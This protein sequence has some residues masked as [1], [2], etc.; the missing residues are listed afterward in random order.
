MDVQS[1]GT[2]LH[3]DESRSVGTPF[4]RRAGQN[5]LPDTDDQG[6]SGGMDLQECQRDFLQPRGCGAEV[7]FSLAVLKL[8]NEFSK[9]CCSKEEKIELAKKERAIVH[10][11]TRFISNPWKSEVQSED[12][13]KTMVAKKEASLGKVGLF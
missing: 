9:H 8:G 7:C 6:D 2:A 10:E 4:C 1:R 3:T 13:L 12:V 5:S 11:N